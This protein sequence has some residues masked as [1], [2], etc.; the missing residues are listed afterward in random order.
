MDKITTI[1]I[2][3]L[4]TFFSSLG[5]LLLKI[6][7]KKIGSLKQKISTIILKII[8]LYIII[9]VLL[10][11]GVSVIF[12]WLLQTNELSFLYPITAINYFFIIALSV[13][14]LK[15]KMNI[16]KWIG[17]IFIVFGIT[18]LSL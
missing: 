5:M 18:L 3:I 14:V 4:L 8:N 9:G 10:Y 15:E 7:S 17:L 6:G 11:L 13:I 2:M 16:N 1:L 12:I